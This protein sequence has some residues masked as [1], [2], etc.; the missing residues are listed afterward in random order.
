[1]TTAAAIATLY[2]LLM[3]APIGQ[4]VC[5]TTHGAAQECAIKYEHKVTFMS[6]VRTSPTQQVCNLR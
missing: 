1:M 6:C 2:A 3:P 4:P 5:V